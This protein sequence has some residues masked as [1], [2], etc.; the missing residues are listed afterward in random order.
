MSDILN[1]T[2]YLL[3]GNAKFTVRHESGERYTYHFRTPKT[4]KNKGIIIASLLTGSNNDDDFTEVGTLNPENGELTLTG[5]IGTGESRNTVPTSIALLRWVAV[6][7]VNA[8]PIPEGLT[9]HHSGHCLRCGR[10]LTV[11]YPDNPYR[12]HGLGPECGS[13]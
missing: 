8:E 3:A 10:T 11:P 9:I 5:K 6:L 4:G 12:I 7:A 2:K 1:T 13:K